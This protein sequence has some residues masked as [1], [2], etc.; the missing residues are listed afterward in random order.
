M[1]SFF[2][3]F[4]FTKRDDDSKMVLVRIASAFL[5]A[6]VVYNIA[7]EP[8]NIDNIGNFTQ[9]NLNDLFEWGNQRFVMGQIAD[10]NQPG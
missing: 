3:L 10:Q 6:F 7:Q 4:S 5:L 2:P 8:E 9:D 1:D